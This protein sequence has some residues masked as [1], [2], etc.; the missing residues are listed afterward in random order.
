MCVFRELAARN[1]RNAIKGKAAGS[2]P[3]GRG[4]ELTGTPSVVSYPLT[5]GPTVTGARG[6]E[7]L[8]PAQAQCPKRVGAEQTLCSVA[9]YHRTLCAGL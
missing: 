9:P 4:A 3:T 2:D 1:A 5:L 8:R 6:W 7:E